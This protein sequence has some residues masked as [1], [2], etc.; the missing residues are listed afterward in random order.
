MH[1][2]RHALV[3]DQADVYAIHATDVCRVHAT[4]TERLALCGYTFKLNEWCNLYDGLLSAL[5]VA[6]VCCLD[7]DLEIIH[8]ARYVVE[9]SACVK[10]L[11]P[12]EVLSRLDLV[13]EDYEY[14]LQ[15][16]SPAVQIQR[17]TC[18]QSDTIVN[19]LTE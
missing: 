16:T 7:A 4:C 3:S 6:T 1:V 5:S 11:G 13:L 2:M 9:S 15:T 17:C 8:K 18:M 12:C 10:E 19:M 14:T